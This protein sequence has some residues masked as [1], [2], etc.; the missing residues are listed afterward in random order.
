MQRRKLTI[1]MLIFFHVLKHC[2]ETNEVAVQANPF[3]VIQ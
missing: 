3:I 1:K 2:I